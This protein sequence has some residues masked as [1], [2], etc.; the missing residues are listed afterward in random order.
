MVLYHSHVSKIQE[1]TFVPIGR[2]WDFR[3]I[4]DVTAR[5]DARRGASRA[6]VEKK[7]CYY[8]YFIA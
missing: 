1:Y 6:Q 4:E 2:R 3:L 8:N 7:C 5:R